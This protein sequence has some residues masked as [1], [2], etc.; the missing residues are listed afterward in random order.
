M[1]EEPRGLEDGD[2]VVVL[3]ENR[4]RRV[5]A[6][7]HLAISVPD[8]A[9]RPSSTSAPGSSTSA[10]ST[11]TCPSRTARFRREA[12][13]SGIDRLQ[14]ADDAELGAHSRE[15][16]H[17]GRRGPQLDFRPW[18]HD[19]FRRRRERFYER[20]GEGIALLFA[21]PE[22][23]LG[24]DLHYRYRPDPDLC[25]LTGFPEPE[26][27]AVLD[28]D[29]RRFTL[30]VRPKDR[31]RETWEGRRAGPEGAPARLRRRRRV[32]D[33]RSSRRGSPS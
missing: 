3:V 33:R 7:P 29:R 8:D 13:A 26:A 32:P 30:F 5:D 17:G 12:E 23:S 16:S 15:S 10:P 31:E 1:R 21:T 6:P 18:Q 27:V 20:M 4:E 9:G 24:W 25:Y 28:A 11:V 2:R 14:A 22:A 19:L